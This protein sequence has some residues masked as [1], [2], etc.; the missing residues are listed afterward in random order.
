MSS[1]E[2]LRFLS[3][4]FQTFL[5]HCLPCLF[6]CSLLEF[7]CRGAFQLP[8]AHLVIILNPTLLIHQVLCW[9]PLQRRPSHCGHCRKSED[10]RKQLVMASSPH[11]YSHLFK[12]FCSTS[13]SSLKKQLCI[14]CGLALSFSLSSVFLNLFLQR[15]LKARVEVSQNNMGIRYQV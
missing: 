11:S 13:T 12:N 15:L 5:F 2:L 9:D 10:S 6:Q 8:A 7:R 14:S 4:P 1:T 3:L